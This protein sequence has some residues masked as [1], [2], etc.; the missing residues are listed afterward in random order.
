MVRRLVPAD[1]YHLL[2]TSSW[3]RLLGLLA[4]AYGAANALFALGYLLEPGALEN[5][6]PGSFAD[7]F[8]FSVQTMATIGYGRMVPRTFLANALVTLETLTGLLALAMVT[9][10]VFAKFSRPTARVLFSRVAVIGRPITEASPLHGA[11][12]A[13]LAAEEA[14]IVVSVVGLDE[15]YAQTVHARHS[16]AA[17]DIVWNARFADVVVREPDGEVHI[18]YARFHDVVPVVTCVRP[19]GVR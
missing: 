11:T 15:S 14:R 3:P 9:G 2:L 13:S 16:Y 8:F 10:L 1:L 19:S 17:E 7:A 6:R 4:L 18:D 5:A 12:A